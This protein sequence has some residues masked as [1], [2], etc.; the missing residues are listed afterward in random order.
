MGSSS[1]TMGVMSPVKRPARTPK[2][3]AVGSEAVDA[4]RAGLL[5]LVPATDVGEHLGVLS[6]EGKVVTHL[7]ACLR[8]GYRGWR[9]SVTVSRAPRQKS[10]TVDEVVLLPGADALVAPPWVPWRERIQP[11][12]LSPG[13]LLPTQEDDPRLV[14][15]YADPDAGLDPDEVRS[16]ADELGLGRPRVV[17]AE[18]REDA[19]ERWYDGA[20]GPE[21]PI[22]QEI[23]RASCRERV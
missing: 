2:L 22:A 5:D 11:G 6:E 20:G 10:V 12:D 9:W 18:G 15:G 1:V 23:G 17:S 3:D 4:A 13:D 21:A 19:A 16:I 14:P 8:A 7:F